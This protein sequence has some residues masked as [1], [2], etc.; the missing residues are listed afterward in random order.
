MLHNAIVPR[1]REKEHLFIPFLILFIL[2]QRRQ[3]WATLES[4]AHLIYFCSHSIG[5]SKSVAKIAAS[6]FERIFRRIPTVRVSTVLFL[7]HLKSI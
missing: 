1:L 4:A 7:L 3:S 5:K 2:W 6:V